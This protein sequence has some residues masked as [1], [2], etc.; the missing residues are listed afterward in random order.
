MENR[1]IRLQ[2][3]LKRSLGK[4]VEKRSWVMVIDVD[5]CIGCHACTVACMAENALPPGVSYR[6][7][8]DTED[9]EFPKVRR[10]FMPT[11]CQQCDNPPCV[12]GL[13][14][15]AYTKRPDGI[16]VFHYEKMKG[17]QL[18]DQVKKQ[19]PYTAVYLDEGRFYTQGTPK[20]QPYETRP[21]FDYGKRWVRSG[22]GSSP[23]EAI[24]KCHFCLH[25]LESGMLPACVTTCVG[26]AMHFGD[27]SDP[28]AFIQELLQKRSAL[29]INEAEGTQPR[30]WYVTGQARR[31]AVCADCHS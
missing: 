23:V 13:P 9:G 29:R 14:K 3:D 28:D 19:C 1:L 5:K 10:F 17:H 6:V 8:F 24:R 22:S 20:L 26:G 21:S 12:Q 16:L 27:A 2:Q 31:P 4:P 18:F 15:D 11:N 25:R 30:V 7:V